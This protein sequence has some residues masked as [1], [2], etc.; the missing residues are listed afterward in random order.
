[1]ADF[2]QFVGGIEDAGFKK[3]HVPWHKLKS[4][5]VSFEVYRYRMHCGYVPFSEIM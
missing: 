5:I 3:K 2:G 4:S 1:M